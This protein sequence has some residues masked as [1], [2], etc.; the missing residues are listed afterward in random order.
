MPRR[1]RFENQI[2]RAS[3]HAA[4]GNGVG[5]PFPIIKWLDEMH[6]AGS[7]GPTLQGVDSGDE[8]VVTKHARVRRGKVV[9]RRFV[10]KSG[11]VQVTACVVFI[12]GEDGPAV[13]VDIERALYVDVP[14]VR[15]QVGSAHP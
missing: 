2:S 6:A 11:A 13:R 3:A 15:A 10:G 5:G 1:S 12:A 7:A 9:A 8:I 4:A 14:L